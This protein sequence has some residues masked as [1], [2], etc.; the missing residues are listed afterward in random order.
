MVPG[1]Y[2]LFVADQY[3]KASQDHK[4]R[5]RNLDPPK[6]VLN[7]DS[8][9]VEAPMNDGNNCKYSNSQKLCREVR[10]FRIGCEQHVLGENDTIR[11][12]EAK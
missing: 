4:D 12:G 7:I 3:R 8:G 9:S 5:Q 1:R 11:S 2:R 10:G 6:R